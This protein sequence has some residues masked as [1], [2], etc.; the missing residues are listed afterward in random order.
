MM[1]GIGVAVLIMVAL[2]V[3]FGLA[4][5]QQKGAISQVSTGAPHQCS[6]VP[7][8][9]LKSSP[10]TTLKACREKARVP[11]QVVVRGR[12]PRI[13]PVEGTMIDQAAVMAANEIMKRLDPL[14]LTLANAFAFRALLE[15]LHGRNLSPIKEPHVSAIHMV[16]AG[17]IR[18]AIGTIM[19]AV[20]QRRADRASIGQIVHMFDEMNISVFT[21]RWAD[22]SFGPT[23]L[24]RAKDDWG[25]L[26]ATGDFQDCKDFRDGAIGHTLVL[27]LPSVPNE[28]YFRVLDAAEEITHRFYRICGYGK[29]SFPDHKP[30]LTASAKAFWDTYFK[31][32]A[33]G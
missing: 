11:R 30:T 26:L 6:K 15:D 25:A 28:A 13:E 33:T 20:D 4:S 1:K 29:P 14:D 17:I 16:R 10:P 7:V 18:A 21:D 22:A 27:A 5:G 3:V 32:M 23:E 19:A 9:F 12:Q 31:G 8:P 24:Q 2:L